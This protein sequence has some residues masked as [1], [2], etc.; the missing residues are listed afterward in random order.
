M[1][2]TYPTS[3][4]IGAH[5][6]VL[7]PFKLPRAPEHEHEEASA[8]K[9]LLSLFLAVTSFIH[10]DAHPVHFIAQSKAPCAFCVC[11]ELRQK[12]GTGPGKLRDPSDFSAQRTRRVYL[13]LIL[14]SIS[15]FL[16]LQMFSSPPRP[17]HVDNIS[18]CVLPMWRRFGRHQYACPSSRTHIH[19][20]PR[21]TKLTRR[22]NILFS[23]HKPLQTVT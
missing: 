9:R 21:V 1:P 3:S 18:S 4:E 12:P 23:V 6:T 7:E 11:V 19:M 8:G 5:L 17:N 15:I 16:A 22:L 2:S 14:N 20:S 13:L 10:S